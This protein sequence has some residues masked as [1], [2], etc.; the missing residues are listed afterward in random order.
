MFTT[1]TPQ[2]IKIYFCHCT[3]CRHQSSSAF[4]ISVIFPYFEIPDPHG[5]IGTYSR[6][7]ASEKTLECL[8]CKNCGSRLMHRNPLSQLGGFTAT[9][10]VKGG[11]LEGL[12]R[13]MLEE[14]AHIWCKEAVAEIPA[15]AERW[16]EEP[17]E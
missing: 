10:S 3:E 12:S 13:E 15:G 14:A 6:T 8:F 1:P 5:R 7:T 4:G 11:C 9:V 17:L 16:E 2:P